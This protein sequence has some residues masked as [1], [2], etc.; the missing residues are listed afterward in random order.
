MVLVRPQLPS[1][2]TLGDLEEYDPLFQH[3]SRI[4]V[5]AAPQAHQNISVLV[6]PDVDTAEKV[7]LKQVITMDGQNYT[8]STAYVTD[9]WSSQNI[10]LLNTMV[11][12][13]Q[14]PSS[15]SDTDI[16]EKL[17][18]N[19]KSSVSKVNIHAEKSLAV[20]ILNDP[21]MINSIIK[22][23]NITFESK[24]ASIA[25]AHLVIELP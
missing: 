24:V 15:V 25:P 23:N 5:V 6:F 1:S 3:I 4:F 21:D 16:L 18:E 2:V 9:S 20:L 11:F 12:L 7:L 22:L 19:I 13:T 17:P 8:V 14:V 10:V